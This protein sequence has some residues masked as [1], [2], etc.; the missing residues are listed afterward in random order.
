MLLLPCSSSRV[1]L[2]FLLP[3][4]PL[5]GALGGL[6]AWLPY[7]EWVVVVVVKAVIRQVQARRVSGRGVAAGFRV[8]AFPGQ[9][10]GDVSL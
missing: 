7:E 9:L 3:E 1:R 8:R 5:T 4:A 10:T 2:V 6:G